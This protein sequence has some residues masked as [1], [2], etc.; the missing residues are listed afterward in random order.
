MELE[1]RL[2]PQDEIY[3]ILI[4]ALIEKMPLPPDDWC[5]SKFDEEVFKATREFEPNPF[6][7]QKDALKICLCYLVDYALRMPE[8]VNLTET[9]NRVKEMCEELAF[10]IVKITS[11][12]ESVIEKRGK[13]KS[14]LKAILAVQT[15]LIYCEETDRY[16]AEQDEAKRLNRLA[17]ANKKSPPIK[18]KSEEKWQSDLAKTIFQ[19]AGGIKSESPSEQP[20]LF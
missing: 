15:C 10:E 19:K 18:R 16:N 5:V 2:L 9:N 12:P 8:R 13:L 7:R 3:K 1:N 17:Q 20:G 6:L 4:A 14:W 11:E